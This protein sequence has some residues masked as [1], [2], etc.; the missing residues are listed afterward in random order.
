[1]PASAQ[2]SQCGHT[3]CAA[4]KSGYRSTAGY[5][6]SET[7]LTVD[8]VLAG[9][10]KTK[11]V[12]QQRYRDFVQQSKGQPSPRQQLKN[13]I[14]LGDDDLASGAQCKLDPDNHSKTY[15]KSKNK[16]R[17]AISLLCRTL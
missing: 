16:P 11:N 7:C 17:K 15:Q 6:E 5:E 10:A 8:W 13:L 12:A 3:W 14:Y 4:Q 9:F 1:M 2:G